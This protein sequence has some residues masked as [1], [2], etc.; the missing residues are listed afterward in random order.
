MA[1]IFFTLTLLVASMQQQVQAT[2]A[3]DTTA[4]T[5]L[6]DIVDDHLVTMN[7][8]KHEIS[9][10]KKSFSSK[11]KN[12]HTSLNETS[13]DLVDVKTQVKEQVA[14][15]VCYVFKSEALSIPS[16]GTLKFHNV[17]TNIGNVYSSYTGVFTDP[18]A[19]VYVF[20]LHFMSNNHPDKISL[21]IVKNSEPLA[22]AIADSDESF[23][24]QDSAF[25]TTHLQKD[26]KVFVKHVSGHTKVISGTVTSFT[27]VLITAE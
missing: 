15:S 13:F 27:G 23:W 26:D 24:A 1:F 20:F 25:V 4:V 17:I 5:S 12:L 2:E 14:F 11:M 22:V 8:M 19:G 9:E 10:L 21:A 3:C 18:R 7:N 6:R 16:M